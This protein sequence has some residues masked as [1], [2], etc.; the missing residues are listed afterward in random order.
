MYSAL[1]TGGVLNPGR[2]LVHFS[3]TCVL[4]IDGLNFPVVDLQEL[5]KSDTSP[6][7]INQIV[8][9]NSLLKPVQEI[10]YTT[11]RPL[12]CVGNQL[13]VFGDLDI[14]NSLPEGNVLTFSHGGKTVTFRHVE[15]NQYPIPITKD[16]KSFPQ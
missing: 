14:D 11:Q 8:V 6:R 5:V 9:L 16:R 1:L 15:A 3:N 2:E 10:E 7:G 13:Y 4:H 12:F